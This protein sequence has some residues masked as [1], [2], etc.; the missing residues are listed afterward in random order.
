[1]PSLSKP[2][3]AGGCNALVP[4]GSGCCA[5]HTRTRRAVTDARRGSARQRGYSAKWDAY[6]RRFVRAHPF[7]V[8][9]QRQG[10]VTAAQC[11]DHIVPHKGD[12]RLMWDPNNHQ[13]ICLAHNSAKAVREEGGF[14]FGR[15]TPP[16]GA[17]LA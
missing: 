1:M 9:C 3:S 4:V 6:S 16:K 12:A 7:C 8:E 15:A 17:T 5:V 13:A 2:C 14:G 11:T 10:R